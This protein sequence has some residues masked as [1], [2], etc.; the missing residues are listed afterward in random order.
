MFDSQRLPKI[1]LVLGLFLFVMI[2]FLPLGHVGMEMDMETGMMSNCLLMSSHPLLCASNTLLHLAS[3]QGMFA[4]ILDR[5]D[6]SLLLF[7]LVTLA[8]AKYAGAPVTKIESPPR[9]R[10]AL[11]TVRVPESR[12]LQELFSNGILNPK[13]Y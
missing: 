12:P 10:Y 5:I 2:G 1:L 9:L 7:V 6:L 8:L 3:W 11:Q 4:S 13:Y